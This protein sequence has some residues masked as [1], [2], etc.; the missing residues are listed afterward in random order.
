MF[1]LDWL[2]SH[3]AETREISSLDEWMERYWETVSGWN[4]PIDRAMAGG[5]TSDRA[6]YA[7]AAGYEAALTRLVPSL[8]GRT[9]VSI[10]ITEEKGGHPGMIKST[11]RKAAGE[12]GWM[13][14]GSKRFTTLAGAADLFLV[15]ASTGTTTDNKNIIRLVR[16][17]RNAP[18]IEIAP[19]PGLPFVPE[20]GH[21]ALTFNDVSVADSDMLPGDGYT[22]YIRPFRTVEDVH[23]SAAIA[24]FVL[25]IACLYQWPTGFR[26]QLAGL[27]AG[28]RSLALEDPASPGVHIALGGLGAQMSVLFESA[29][30]F[31]EKTD[32]TTRSRWERDRVLLGVA[33]K[34]RVSR[35]ARAWTRF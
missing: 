27:L 8:P 23:V 34:S 26:E 33:E 11:L 35:L 10:S 17:K 16:V 32:A 21:G 14:N 2:L 15:A 29:A 28:M 7:F 24:A 3:E 5:F 12:S 31:W 13:L 30:V 22:E 9:I 1:I 19:M 25:R 18:G 4:E 6:G 20:I